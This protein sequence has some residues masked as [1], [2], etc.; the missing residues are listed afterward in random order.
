VLAAAS[1][2]QAAE[3]HVAQMLAGRIAA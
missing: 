2:V 3:I 1:Y